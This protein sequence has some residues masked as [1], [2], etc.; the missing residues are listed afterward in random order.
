MEWTT[1]DSRRP[2]SCLRILRWHG[3]L[4]QVGSD[5]VLDLNVAEVEVEGISPF[6]KGE[7]VGRC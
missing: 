2:I 1:Q 6:A 3:Y 4:C 7:G 5:K